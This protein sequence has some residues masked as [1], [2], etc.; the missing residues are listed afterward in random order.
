MSA[1]TLTHKNLADSLGVSETTIK[2]YRRKFPGCFPVASS[3]KPIRFTES[4]LDVALR[5]QALFALGMSIPEV[6]LRL[7][8]EFSWITPGDE[9]A[10]KPASDLGPEEI[11]NG[12]S[13]LAKSMVSMG[14][15]QHAIAKR[16]ATLEETLRTMAAG[17]GVNEG[18][19]TAVG[20]AR[21]S[22]SALTA[23]TG[24]LDALEEVSAKLTRAMVTVIEKLDHIAGAAS[25]GPAPGSATGMAAARPSA[26]ASPLPPDKPGQA[27][28]RGPADP[29]QQPE[30]TPANNV[31]A[32]PTRQQDTQP[33]NLRPQAPAQTEE[34][35]RPF[36]GLPLLARTG[37]GRFIS[38]S[39]RSRGKL[40]LND[41]KAMLVY[42][43][44]PPNHYSLHWEKSSSGWWLHL[45]QLAVPDS[46]RISLLL[47]EV[48][49][50]QGGQGFLEILR[51]RRGEQ[52][53]HP[54]EMCAI[55]E[56][57]TG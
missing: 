16:M 49:I 6:R 48:Q 21:E 31:V 19:G 39:S 24:R 56:S 40:N 9:K 18:A 44:T 5:V 20:P 36:F 7:A 22:S 26:T 51:L 23:L 46:E 34:P 37:D 13:T 38:A 11:Q 27:S 17:G 57:F 4:S 45:E 1:P 2:S 53:L 54:T 10:A 33:E 50:E 29:R 30:E 35:P 28:A 42:G 14:Q 8:N 55:V 43:F 47:A 12:L 32:F 25:A 3:G 15:Q 52:V 41:L